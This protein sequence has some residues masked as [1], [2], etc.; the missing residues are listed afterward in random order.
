MLGR[1]DVNGLA[2]LYSTF[3]NALWTRGRT[4]RRVQG[5]MVYARLTPPWLTKNTI[6]MHGPSRNISLPCTINTLPSKNQV[7]ER[8]K[9]MLACVILDSWMKKEGGSS[10][11]LSSLL[12][13]KGL[14]VTDSAESSS[15]IDLTRRPSSPIADN[16]TDHG[17]GVNQER[18][19]G[20]ILHDEQPHLQNL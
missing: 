13:E 12:Q 7:R 5:K 4:V 9:K 19:P 17:T 6:F 15:T 8:G 16:P 11:Y 20:E 18:Q 10:L 14:S 3:F 1:L 2:N